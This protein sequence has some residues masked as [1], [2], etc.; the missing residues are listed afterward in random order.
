MPGVG[1]NEQINITTQ[2]DKVNDLLWSLGLSSG[3]VS[4]SFNLWRVRALY[5]QLQERPHGFTVSSQ[6]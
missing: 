2:N 4:S 3:R 1:K 6:V 5:V